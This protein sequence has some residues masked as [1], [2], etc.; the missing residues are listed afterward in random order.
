MNK[1]CQSGKFHV[2]SHALHGYVVLHR[3]A[4][5]SGNTRMRSAVESL[6]VRTTGVRKTLAAAALGSADR[7]NLGVYISGGRQATRHVTLAAGHTISIDHWFRPRPNRRRHFRAGEREAHAPWQINNK[8]AAG[9]DWGTNWMDA[10]Q[11]R[12][13]RNDEIHSRVTQRVFVVN[14]E[15]AWCH[16]NLSH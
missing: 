2:A 8:M 13:R 5:K 1:L 3:G 7:K 12:G 11:R 16:F 6:S 15:T 10:G 14:T 4:A 9:P